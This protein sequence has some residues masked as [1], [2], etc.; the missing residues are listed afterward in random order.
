MKPIPRKE[1]SMSIICL[2][3][4]ENHNYKRVESL[5]ELKIS[6][7]PLADKLQTKVQAIL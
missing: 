1:I 6:V 5:R 4:T 3:I 2:S 7:F